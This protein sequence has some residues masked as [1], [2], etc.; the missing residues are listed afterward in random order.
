MGRK[1]L[2][3][4]RDRFGDEYKS[5]PHPEPQPTMPGGAD[6]PVKPAVKPFEKFP[7]DVDKIAMPK[8][9]TSVVAAGRN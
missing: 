6:A 1:S 2:F 5:M 8:P 7:I 3:R 9:A 4:P